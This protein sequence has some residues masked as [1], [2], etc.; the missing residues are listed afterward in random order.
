[1]EGQVPTDPELIV[2]FLQQTADKLLSILAQPHGIDQGTYDAA[3][4]EYQGAAIL[5]DSA[6]AYKHSDSMRSTANALVNNRD[7]ILKAIANLRQTNPEAASTAARSLEPLLNGATRQIALARDTESIMHE[8]GKTG[9]AQRLAG[10]VFTPAGRSSGALLSNQL[11]SQRAAL[12][13]QGVEQTNW[14]RAIVA[15]IRDLPIT[16]A[17]VRARAGELGVKVSTF[18]A[19]VRGAFVAARVAAPPL[20]ESLLVFLVRFGSRLTTPILVIGDPFH[21]QTEIY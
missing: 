7:A 14:V 5:K 8:L 1:M 3:L 18:A 6:D 13:P 9:N 11:S 19:G 12:L 4:A 2:A 21:P 17:E 10:Y 15:R 20:I 16:P